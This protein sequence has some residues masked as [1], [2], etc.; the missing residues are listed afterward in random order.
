MNQPQ[1]RDEE[2]LQSTLAG[3]EQAFTELYR[4]RQAGVFRFALQMSG[5]RT[6]AE[7]VTQEVFLALL[8]DGARYDPRRG[9]VATYLYGIARNQ[10][11]R[12][13]ERRGTPEPESDEGPAAPGDVVEDL[14]RDENVRAVRDAVLSLPEHYREA[15][16]LCAL[17]ELSYEEAAAALGCA[18]GTVRSRMHRGRG[19][20]AE[21]LQLGAEAGA[22]RSWV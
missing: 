12:W 9:S 16:V 10:V 17:H 2:L 11:L 15:V 20:L 1:T 8:R 13:L 3:E 14:L 19:L 18:V 21:K 7:D 6:A 5:S 22:A 4:R